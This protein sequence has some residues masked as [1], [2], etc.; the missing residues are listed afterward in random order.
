MAIPTGSGLELLRR[1]SVISLTT[2]DT[3]LNFTGVITAPGATNTVPANHIITVLNI[4][5]TETQAAAETFQLVAHDGTNAVNLLYNVALA[6]EGTFVW[7]TKFVLHGGDYMM[8]VASAGDI[9][10]HYSY[11]DQDWS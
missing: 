7:N 8:T 3:K 6:G 2:G 10:V 1:G 4:I 11:L 5:W 9:D